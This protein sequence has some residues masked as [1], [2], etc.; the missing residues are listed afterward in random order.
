MDRPLG[1]M[2]YLAAFAEILEQSKALGFIPKSVVLATGSAGTQAGLA[3]G[4]KMLSPE[5]RIVGIS[6]SGAAGTIS[7]Y[8]KNIAD[9][10]LKEMGERSS[11]AAE[12]VIVFDEYVGEGYG[13]LNRQVSE[14]IGLVAREEGVLLDPVYTGKAMSGLMGLA[15]KGYF[16]GEDVVFLHTGGTPALFPYRKGL[17]NDLRG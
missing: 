4:A 10:L 7:R 6:V 5:T 13:I 12:E 1:A 2:A 11:V 3:A 15:G 16:D 9:A 17:L 14:V 8:V